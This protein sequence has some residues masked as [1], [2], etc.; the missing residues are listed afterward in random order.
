MSRGGGG[1][2]VRAGQDERGVW[3]YRGWKDMVCT[4]P[5]VLQEKWVKLNIWETSK[6]NGWGNST[7][8]RI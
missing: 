6:F 1:V 4:L 5:A 2:D 8:A 3:L 7:M